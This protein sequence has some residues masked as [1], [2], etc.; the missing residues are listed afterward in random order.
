MRERVD[1][2]GGVLESGRRPDGGYALK[3]RLPW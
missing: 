1:V 3:V 2:Y